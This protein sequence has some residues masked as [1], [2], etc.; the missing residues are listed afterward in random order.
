MNEEIKAS[1][2]TVA[3]GVVA[4]IKLKDVKG[5]KEITIT[6]EGNKEPKTGAYE[7]KMQEYSTAQE[8]FNALETASPVSRE[9]ALSLFNSALQNRAEYK[10]ARYAIANQEDDGTTYEIPAIVGL[11]WAAGQIETGR[12]S[13]RKVA[14]QAQ[15]ELLTLNP[16]ELGPEAFMAKFQE[17]TAK[18]KEFTALADQQAK[19]RKPRTKKTKDDKK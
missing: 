9:F 10:A 13:Y 7:F 8:L 19:E 5:S 14:E 2:A 17:L 12:F 1:E 6:V 11:D 15:Q 4:P 3:N 18:V 16:V